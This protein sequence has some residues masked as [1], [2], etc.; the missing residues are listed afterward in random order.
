MQSG[1]KIKVL[2]QAGVKLRV[3]S[4]P[5]KYPPQNGPP[6]KLAIVSPYN[7]LCGIADYTLFLVQ[8]L[9]KF[10]DVTVYELDQDVLK[11]KTTDA[12]E[13]AKKQLKLLCNQL[14]K[15]DAVNLQFET[16]TL[17]CNKHSAYDRFTQIIDESPV[18]SVTF[19]TFKDAIK[20]SRGFWKEVS[21]LRFL[22]AI[23]GQSY[24]RSHALTTHKPIAY[25]NKAAGEKS[26]SF[27]VHA[28]REVQRLT[29]QHDVDPAIVYDHPLAYLNQELIANLQPS[30]VLESLRLPEQS[31]V[32]GLFGFIAPYKGTDLAVDVMQQLPE[33]HHLLIAGELHPSETRK[34]PASEHPYLAGIL[35]KIETADQLFK[36]QKTTGRLL[37][38][39]VHFLGAQDQNEFLSLMNDCDI[40]LLPYREAGQVSSGPISMAIELKKRV[41]ASDAKVFNEFTK[42]HPRRI[43]QFKAEDVDNMSQRILTPQRLEELPVNF[44]W[45]TN[46]QTYFAAHS[47]QPVTDQQWQQAEEEAQSLSS[48][49]SRKAA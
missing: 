33:N 9:R 39:R 29:E 1:K 38:E 27:V 46:V 44:D 24:S 22:T 48:N 31:V 34:Y 7:C 20:K 4:Y 43:E 8:S 12:R 14:R 6:P 49:E 19:H 25:L 2:E 37:S 36:V 21:Q 42:Y 32:L 10:A 13:H 45:R 11:Q 18:V 35:N 26:V 41:I 30:K 47:F 23:W 5:A 40:V 16:G 3:L 28:K 17:G 15:H